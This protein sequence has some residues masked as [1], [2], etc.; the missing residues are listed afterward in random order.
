MVS[1]QEAL[2]TLRK[3]KNEAGSEYG[4]VS[5][6]LFGSLARDQAITGSDVDVVV[7]TE[8]VDAFQIV[9]IKEALEE[10][11]NIHVDIVRKR[12]RMNEFLKQRIEEEA[13]YV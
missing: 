11:L 9:H 13:V 7:E 10:L 5:L 4:I 12:D 6:G 2:M 3:F 8:K 1:R